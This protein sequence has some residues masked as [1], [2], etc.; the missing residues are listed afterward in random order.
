MALLAGAYFQGAVGSC[1][2]CH[3][4]TLAPPRT[5]ASMAT[6]P[7]PSADGAAAA[8]EQGEHSVCPAV[9]PAPVVVEHVP[10]EDDGELLHDEV[11]APESTPEGG[12]ELRHPLDAVSDVELLARLKRDPASLGA[13]SLGLPNKGSL[14]NAVQM[15]DDPR[16]VRVDKGRAWGTEETVQSLIRAIGRVAQDYPDS[17]ALNVG[18]ISSPKGGFLR[19]HRSH[20]SGRDVDLGFYY[21]DGGQWYLAAD[22]T[23]LDR[24]RTWLLVRTL[25]AETDVHFILI[26]HSIQTLLREHAEE[27]GEDPA[28][29]DDVF[30]GS[31]PTRPAVIRHAP[32]HRTHMHV[33]FYNPIAQETARRSHAAM[34][35]LKLIP[36]S[37][38]FAEHKAKKGETLT[39]IAKSYGTTVDAIKRANGL[40]SNKILA[41]RV[42]KVPR[43]GPASAGAR[44]VV[45]PRRIPPAPRALPKPKL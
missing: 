9:S 44:V 45:P 34:V 17:P 19:P 3:C 18:H 23:S 28:W 41:R 21:Q 43:T 7:T 27:V 16:W 38:H 31:G 25:I 11:A 13:M 40:R 32:G 2:P 12:Q 39:H 5:V 37:Q 6:P 4:P 36:S 42:Y 20:Q 14:F 35:Q 15:P 29:L 10:L 24:E 33:R 26:D 1:A 30:R 8:N 22:A